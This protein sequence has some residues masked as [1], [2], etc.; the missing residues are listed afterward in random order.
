MFVKQSPYKINSGVAESVTTSAGQKT[1]LVKGGTY[2]ISNAGAAIAYINT[3]NATATAA[4]LPIAVGATLMPVLLPSGTIN[5]KGV[6]STTL[7]IVKIE[8]D[9][10]A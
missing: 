8:A 4:D 6:A 7:N 1:G 10:T 9:G 3:A 5:H 2:A